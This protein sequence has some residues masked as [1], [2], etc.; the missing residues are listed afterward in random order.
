MDSPSGLFNV[1]SQGD[2]IIRGVAI[3]LLVMSLLTWTVLILKWMQIARLQRQAALSE[4]YW[5]APD[6]SAGLA[7]LDGAK[8]RH[9]PSN[10]FHQLASRGHQATLHLD[11]RV[12]ATTSTSASTATPIHPVD[13]SEWVTR[14]LRMAIDDAAAPLHAGL[15]VLASVGSTAPFIGLFGTVWG[16]YH[17]LMGLGQA[18]QTTM[19]QVAGPVGEALVMTALGLAVAIP[20]VLGYNLLIR[21]NKAAISLLHRFAHDLHTCLITGARIA[22]TVRL[23]GPT[24]TP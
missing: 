21:R 7:A 6:L 10:P 22:P 17:A 20:A 5:S 19:D 11:A 3:I 4:S 24:A 1:W 8:A 23:A 16:I 9:S 14:H 13:R 2:A 12:T 15:A 18:G